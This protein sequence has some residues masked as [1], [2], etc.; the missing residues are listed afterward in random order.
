MNRCRSDLGD[1]D[2]AALA[3]QS[4]LACQASQARCEAPLLPLTIEAPLLLRTI[5]ATPA[6]RVASG[7]RA[8]AMQLLARRA[9]QYQ[10]ETCS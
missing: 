6:I 3:P 1:V 2:C 7:P 9:A 10:S 8:L 4:G 5:E